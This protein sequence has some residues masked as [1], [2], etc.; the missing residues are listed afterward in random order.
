MDKLYVLIAAFVALESSFAYYS[1]Y[2]FPGA[3]LLFYGLYIMIYLGYINKRQLYSRNVRSGIIFFSFY[4]GIYIISIFHG[5]LPVNVGWLT[6]IYGVSF[7]FC[8]DEIQY[9]VYRLFIK[10]LSILLFISLI[11]FLLYNFIGVS[12]IDATIQRGDRTYHHLLFNVFEYNEMALMPRFQSILD[13]PG[14]VGTYSALILCCIWGKS[15][16]LFEKIVLFMSGVLSFSLAFYIIILIVVLFST[17]IKIKYCL[18]AIIILIAIYIILK[19]FIDA[20]VL[21][22]FYREDVF[23]RTAYRFDLAFEN[24]W[25]NG[26][27]WFG[28]GALSHKLVTE[29]GDGNAGIKV[30]I[31]QYG[32]IGLLFIVALYTSI[33]IKKFKKYAKLNITGLTFLLVFWLSFYQRSDIEFPYYIVMF[34]A[35]PVFYNKTISYEK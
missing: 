8:D 22:R 34:F 17:G 25:K 23:S 9:R 18:L 35:F 19:D 7:L 27:L 33:F 26:R 15:G 20:L 5:F 21:S 12:Y 10:F 6:L 16:Y 13:E 14:M 32:I 2:V 31:Y 28:N 4:L 11:E 3:G 24:A 1:F 29:I 30:W